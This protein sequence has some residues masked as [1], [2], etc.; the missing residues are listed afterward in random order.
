MIDLWQLE[1]IRHVKNAIEVF[2]QLKSIL[3][4][5]GLAKMDYKA[6]VG[7]ADKESKK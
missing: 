7:L 3:M 6:T 1:L 5:T 4:R 2:L